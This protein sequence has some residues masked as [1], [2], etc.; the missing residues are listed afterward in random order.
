VR[1]LL[2]PVDEA[3]LAWEHALLRRLATVL[4]EVAAPVPARDGT[5]W[6]RLGDSVAWLMPLVRGVPV[7]PGREEHRRAAARTLGHLHAAGAALDVPPRPGLEPLARMPWPP[8][9]ESGPLAEHAAE[10]AEAREWAMA[11]VERIASETSPRTGLVHGDYFP[12]NVLV[13]GDGVSAVLDW[14]EAQRDWVS[15]D[16]ANALGTFCFE[17]HVLDRPAARRFLAAYHDAGG[18]APAEEQALLVPLMRVK[19]IQELLRAPTDREPRWD[20][21]RQNLRAVRILGALLTQRALP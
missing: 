18:T 12:G 13:D 9:E 21:Q 14:E 2:P 4:P 20:H 5:T 6:F 17:R 1:L 15:W 3:G 8:V 11:Y 19:R 10:L 16:L 7:D